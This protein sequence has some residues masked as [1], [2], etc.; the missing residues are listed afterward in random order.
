MRTLK[1]TLIALSFVLSGVLATNAQSRGNG[2][3]QFVEFGIKGGLNLSNIQNA[4]GDLKTGL[5]VGAYGEY[6]VSETLSIRSEAIFSVQGAK[7]SVGNGK[8]KLNYINWPILVRFYTGDTLSFE[9]G[10]QIGFLLSGRGGGLPSSAY[11]TVDLGAAFGTAYQ[12][13]DRMEVGARYNLG[14]T[15]FT[16][17]PGHFKNSVFQFTLAYRL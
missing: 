15:D 4:N 2:Y 16:K 6:P 17:T 1:Q 3:D 13:T 9:A 12:V 8:I 10:P 7:A 14:L 5:A 11:K